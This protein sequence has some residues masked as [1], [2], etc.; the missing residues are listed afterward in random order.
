VLGVEGILHDDCVQLVRTGSFHCLWLDAHNSVEVVR[1]VIPETSEIERTK[2][3]EISN[4]NTHV[5]VV[6]PSVL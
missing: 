1:S 3:P 5:M 4:P 6:L 2:H